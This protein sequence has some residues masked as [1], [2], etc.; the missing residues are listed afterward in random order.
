[1]Q[2]VQVAC[3]MKGQFGSRLLVGSAGRECLENV[4][5]CRQG[6]HIEAPV[7]CAELYAAVYCNSRW[8]EDLQSHSLVYGV[9]AD[10]ARDCVDRH[11]TERNVRLGVFANA[12]LNRR[13]GSEVWNSR[14]ISAG[15]AGLGRFIRVQQSLR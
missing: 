12:E 11:L 1:M 4:V 15:V 3:E 10:C 2:I 6:E 5:S 9:P 7:F 13:R 8:I 14:V